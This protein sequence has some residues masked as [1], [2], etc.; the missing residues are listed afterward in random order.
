MKFMNCENITFTPIIIPNVFC[1]ALL[2]LDVLSV[3][4]VL[5]PYVC[6]ILGCLTDPSCPA[7]LFLSWVLSASPLDIPNENQ[8]CFIW[9]IPSQ[10]SWHKRKGLPISFFSPEGKRKPKKLL[11]LHLLIILTTLPWDAWEAICFTFQLISSDSLEK[12]DRKYVCL[13][14][15]DIKVKT[16]FFF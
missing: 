1:Q 10:Y 8:F 16:F 14:I 4:N 7:W 9:V 2:A 15:L 6:I 5:C 11:C 13:V 3:C 12:A